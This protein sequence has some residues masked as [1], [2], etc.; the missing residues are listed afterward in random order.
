M[1][2]TVQTCT[3]RKGRISACRAASGDFNIKHPQDKIF[4]SRNGAVPCSFC[5]GTSI[6]LCP[7]SLIRSCA[8]AYLHFIYLKGS[9]CA[10]HCYNVPVCDR[11]KH[12]RILCSMK[13]ERSQDATS[14]YGTAHKHRFIRHLRLLSLPTKRR[15]HELNGAQNAGCEIRRYAPKAS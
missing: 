11:S 8:G 1:C 3:S 15:R 7:C 5:I 10:H 13:A 2:L 6:Q 4:F 14:I 12:L 9:S